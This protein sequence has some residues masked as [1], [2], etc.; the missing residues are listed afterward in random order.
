MHIN[1]EKL[2]SATQSAKDFEKHILQEIV[3]NVLYHEEAQIKQT[4]FVYQ[5]LKYYGIIE[6]GSPASPINPLTG[7]EHFQ[8]PAR[9]N[10]GSKVSL[11]F[12]G[13]LTPGI[14]TGVRFTEGKVRYDI[15][16]EIQKMSAEDIIVTNISNV[17][18]AFV[19]GAEEA[20]MKNA[21]LEESVH[22]DSEVFES[23][24]QLK[25]IQEQVQQ[26]NLPSGVTVRFTN[27]PN[28][29]WSP[30]WEEFSNRCKESAESI[31]I[32][33]QIQK[34]TNEANLYSVSGV[35]VEDIIVLVIPS[36]SSVGNGIF[37]YPHIEYTGDDK[38][39]RRAI[40]KKQ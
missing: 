28:F 10:V 34:I 37:Y 19:E 31:P 29:L 7:E 22:R 15:D 14:V 4:P 9:Y 39:I 21:R 16:L 26:L 27:S 17:D 36:S 24:E 40:I 1:V 18:S 5:V 30:S 20:Y 13:N 11:S 12:C 35:E 2:K 23:S 33:T 32:Q 3:K 8:F 6:D 25:F 38:F